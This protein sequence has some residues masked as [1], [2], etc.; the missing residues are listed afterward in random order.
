MVEQN[1]D[2][3]ECAGISEFQTYLFNSGDNFRSYEIFGTHRLTLDGKKGWR[4]AVWAPKAVSVR[5][6]G[7]FNDWAD[8]G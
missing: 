4:F 7:D 3:K 5:V 8:Y 2:V 6:T 1:Q